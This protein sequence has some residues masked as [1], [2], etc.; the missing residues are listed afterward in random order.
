MNTDHLW[1]ALKDGAH[2]EDASL[3]TITLHQRQLGKLVVSTGQVVA[4]D[5]LVYPDT[6]P[7]QTLIP[8]GHY[9]VFASIASFAKSNDS[10]IAFAHLRLGAQEPVRWELA[11]RAGQDIRSLEEEQF[12]G[13]AVDAGI[14]CFMDIDAAAG[15]QRR[16]DADHG[17]AESLIQNLISQDHVDVTLNSFTGANALMFTPGWGDGFYTSYWGYDASDSTT[18]LIT[19]FALLH[20]PALKSGRP[21]RRRWGLTDPFFR[22]WR[23]RG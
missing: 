10:R 19:D 3:G 1:H 2:I 4:C 21:S 5:P 23:S 12:F 15:L 22:L 13:Y 9:P 16:F 8:P 7:F 20:H 18:C 11:I 14:A 6:K 17:Y